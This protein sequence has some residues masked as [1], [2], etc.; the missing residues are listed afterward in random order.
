GLFIMLPVFDHRVEP[1]LT[2]TIG[3]VPLIGALFRGARYCVRP[4]AVHPSVCH[5]FGYSSAGGDLFTAVVILAI[6]I[7]PII[8]A[9]TRVAIAFVLAALS[10]LLV[11]RTARLVSGETPLGAAEV[12][13]LEV[14]G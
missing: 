1:F 8:T 11:R 6:M 12:P 4:D 7:L 14:T 3:A 13:A 2:R 5:Q 10:R 9:V